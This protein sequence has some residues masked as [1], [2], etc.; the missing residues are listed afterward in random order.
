M[1]LDD[2]EL[3]DVFG[4]RV[5]MMHQRLGWKLVSELKPEEFYFLT[6]KLAGVAGTQGE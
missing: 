4:K 3:E 2:G 5:P 1:L 6:G